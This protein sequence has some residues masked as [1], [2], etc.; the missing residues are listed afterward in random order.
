M[1]RMVGADPR[2]HDEFLR[3][4]LAFV[5]LRLGLAW[6]PGSGEIIV[7]PLLS[8]KRMMFDSE[9]RDQKK[10]QSSSPKSTAKPAPGKKRWWRR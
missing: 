9:R 7:D 5:C 2:T 4:Y 8:L 3:G 1:L 6:N 10:A